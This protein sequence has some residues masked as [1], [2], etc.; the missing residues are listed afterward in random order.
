MGEILD[1]ILKVIGVTSA[2]AGGLWF[3]LRGSVGIYERYRHVEDFPR[4]F[5]EKQ[6]ETTRQLK[7]MWEKL[8]RI[9]SV[10]DAR[11][12]RIERQLNY[13]AGAIRIEI[14]N[15]GGGR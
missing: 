9:D 8:D 3:V 11:L 2:V 1:V 10:T 15:L 12:D 14:E 7:A 5:A 4:D 6:T 13:L